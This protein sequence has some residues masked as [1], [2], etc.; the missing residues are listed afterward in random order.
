M[1]LM[2]TRASSP[3][4]SAMRTA[5]RMISRND[6]LRGRASVFFETAN[7]ALGSAVDERYSTLFETYGAFT[8]L[9]W[10]TF[11][12]NLRLADKFRHIEGC[13]IECGVWR[14]GMMAALASLLGSDRDYFLFDS[15]E[16]LPSAQAIDGHSATEWQA[17][18]RIDNCRTEQRFTEEAMQRSGV[19]SW[20]IVP[21]WF[22]ETLPS[23]D[24]GGPIAIL[25][26][27]ADW[28]SSTAE[29]LNHLYERVAVGG[30]II[31]D[32][33]FTWDGCS[34]AMHAF[35]SANVLTDRIREEPPGVAYVVRSQTGT[36]V[37]IEP[38][39]KAQVVLEN[40][41]AT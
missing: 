19:S 28:Y 16:G 9:E 5:M 1:S 33:Y 7:Q 32:D 12:A 22:E 13:V 40:Y 38:H 17:T 10:H 11:V 24:P 41:Q 35:L 27:D 14:G 8:R 4:R 3:V 30:L 23:F 21:G 2:K 36:I 6:F 15:F 34:R 25:R 37:P 29:C 31:L 39:P 18:N 26:L 20:S